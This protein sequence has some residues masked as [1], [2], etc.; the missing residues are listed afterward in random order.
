M[1][2]SFMTSLIHGLHRYENVTE[3]I[4]EISPDYPEV[5]FETPSDDSIFLDIDENISQLLLPSC[6]VIFSSGLV[7][8]L[9]WNI[10]TE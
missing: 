5:M 10:I 9:L 4:E 2:S 6:F 3:L 1:T 8:V 7:T